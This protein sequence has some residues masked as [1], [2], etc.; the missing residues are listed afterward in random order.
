MESY[1]QLIAILREAKNI[2]FFGGAGVST[3]SGIPDFRSGDGL[4]STD[5]SD[6]LRPEAILHHTFL[7]R[8]PERF[9]AYYRTH[10]IYPDA[11]PNPAHY[12]LAELEAMGKL[13]AVVTQNIDGLHQRAGSKTVL[14]LHGSTDRNYCTRCGRRY[15]LSAVTDPSE[16]VP[17]CTCGGIIRPDVVLYGEPLNDRVW[18]AAEQAISAADVLIVGG[19]SLTVQ[20]AAGMVFAYR[21]DRMI[22]LNQSPT[23]YDRWAHPVIRDPIGQVLGRVMEAL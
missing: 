22:L 1:E 17:I 11:R 18:T 16:P 6:G 3:E 12:A 19:T 5:E 23:P 13:S 7:A 15:G 14:E 21:G 9:Y 8:H 4:Y 20:P 10:M 2:V